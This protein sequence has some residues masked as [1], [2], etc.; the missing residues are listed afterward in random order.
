MTQSE[1]RLI[2]NSQAQGEC[3]AGHADGRVGRSNSIRNRPLS[4]DLWSLAKSV[5]MFP[6][7]QDQ[8][9]EVGLKGFLERIPSLAAANSESAQDL[10]PQR[11]SEGLRKLAVTSVTVSREPCPLSFSSC[12]VRFLCPHPV[13]LWWSQCSWCWEGGVAR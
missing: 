8:D 9:Q 3:L 13:H 4:Q 7:G 2:G 6:G 5:D 10:I 1:A 12:H 11:T